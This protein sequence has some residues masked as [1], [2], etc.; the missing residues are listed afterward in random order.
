MQEVQGE[1]VNGG[2]EVSAGNKDYLFQM[3]AGNNGSFPANQRL[4]CFVPF[5]F[6]L[7]PAC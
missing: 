3:W 5:L 6:S 7:F 4:A 1:A 2:D